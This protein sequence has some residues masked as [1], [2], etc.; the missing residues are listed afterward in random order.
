M[1]NRN[2][3]KIQKSQN[4]GGNNTNKIFTSWVEE[5][6]I[7]NTISYVELFINTFKIKN[8]FCNRNQYEMQKS[9]DGGGNNVYQIF[10]SRVEEENSPNTIS[11]VKLFMTTM[12]M[13]NNFCDGYRYEIQKSWDG[14]GNNAYKIFTSW[15]EEGYFPNTI[16]YVELLMNTLKIK[17]NFCN[18]HQYEMQKSRDGGGNSAYQ[19]FSSR[20]EQGNIQNTISY[21]KLFMT[22]MKM[23]TNF[24]DGYQCQIQKS[25]DVRGNNTYEI[26]MSRVEE[27]YIPNTIAFVELF[28]N[29]FKIKNN[30]CNGV[31]MKCRKPGMEEG[32]MPIK[33]FQAR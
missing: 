30:F 5:G 4:G 15:V 31:S 14:G 24:C 8:N 9:Q 21:V 13:K 19:I 22:T 33:S 2:Q 25:Q 17:N 18:G 16:S 27:G 1:K 23:K 28:M 6:Y 3:Y 7:P 32:I 10:S 12:K 20:V 26:S 29:T 11:Y